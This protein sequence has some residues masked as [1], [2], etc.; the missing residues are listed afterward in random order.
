MDR[1]DLREQNRVSWNAV[2]G[3]HDS[4]RGDLSR[5]FREGGSTLFREETDLLGELEG[6]SLVHL[7]CNSG[8]DSISLARLGATVTGVDLSDEAVSSARD[9]AE[10]T[11]IRATFER[12]DVY[13]WLQEATREG[14]LFDVAFASYGV[15]CWLPDLRSW[16]QGIAGILNPGGRFVL[17]DFHPAADIFDRDWNHVTTT[18][19]AEN[20]FSWKKAS[21]TTWPHREEVSPQPGS[22]RGSETSRTPRVAISFDGGSGRWLRRWPKR[23]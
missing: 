10:K 12:A 13:D 15:I 11:G 14:R 1:R 16:A 4:H 9:L 23:D 7:Q 18:L 8:G 20:R 3:A 21:A 19:P 5:F 22:S 6:R 2:V 17:V